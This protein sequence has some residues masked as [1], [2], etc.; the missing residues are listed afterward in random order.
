MSI[1]SAR[2]ANLRKYRERKLKGLCR[3]CDNKTINNKVHCE[4]HG[5]INNERV[6]KRYQTK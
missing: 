6:K 4:Y 1:F 2:R 3:I 5:K